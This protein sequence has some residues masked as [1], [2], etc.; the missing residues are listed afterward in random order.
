MQPR[1][2]ALLNTYEILCDPSYFINVPNL[3]LNGKDL[4]LFSILHF[5]SK[6]SNRLYVNSRNSL[7]FELTG[8]PGKVLVKHLKK[9]SKSYKTMRMF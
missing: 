4:L 3:Q 9:S 2:T 7:V 8:F 1:S 6:I 5:L